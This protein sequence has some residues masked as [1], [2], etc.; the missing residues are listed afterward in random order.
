MSIFCLL[1][2]EGGVVSRPAAFLLT[3]IH[4]QFYSRPVPTSVLESPC[5][6]TKYV[7]PTGLY[8][9]WYIHTRLV[10]IHGAILRQQPSYSHL[11][12]QLFPIQLYT[13]NGYIPVLFSTSSRLLCSDHGEYSVMLIFM[14]MGI[15]FDTSPAQIAILLQMRSGICCCSVISS[16]CPIGTFEWLFRSVKL[17][18]GAGSHIVP[19]VPS[20]CW[21]HGSSSQ[22]GNIISPAPRQHAWVISINPIQ[23]SNNWSAGIIYQL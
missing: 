21:E 5:Y 8:Y 19:Y 1:C 3:D 14:Q 23:S 22:H 15:L 18:L 10:P 11:V 20:T 13:A 9:T 17:S 6:Q 2:L 16:P 4:I 12:T 7:M